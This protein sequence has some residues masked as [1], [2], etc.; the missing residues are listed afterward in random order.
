M[1]N[2]HAIQRLCTLTLLPATLSGGPVAHAAPATVPGLPA[3]C[4]VPSV[5]TPAEQAACAAAGYGGVATPPAPPSAPAPVPPPVPPAP[6]S[7]LDTLSTPL[8]AGAAQDLLHRL[9]LPG[10]LRGQASHGLIWRAG[11]GGEQTRRDATSMLSGFRVRAETL[12]VGVDRA[13]GDDWAVGAALALTRSRTHFEGNASGQWATSDNLTLYTQWTPWAGGSVSL[14]AS[15][16]QSAYQ[17]QRDGG[18][19]LLARSSPSGSGSGLAL[20]AGHDVVL[21]AWSVSPYLR[22]DQVRVRVDAFQESGAS[23]ALAVGAQAL[24]ACTL[25]AGANLQWSVPQS[26]GLLLPY[27]RMEWSERRDRPGGEVGGRLLSDNS[28]LLIPGAGDER[29]HAGSVAVGFTALTQRSFSTFVDFQTGFAQQ[30]Y[31]IQ[32]L[33]A[34]LRFEL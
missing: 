8:V 17:V 20:T 2:R 21:G 18:G 4:A 11:G 15:H 13:V 32:R 22:W 31:R 29:S 34:G 1:M 33:G 23:D 28:A 16:E 30:G 5:L 25:S 19:G 7:G 26:W 9:R 14:A 3:S 10:A 24:R 6:P 12:S 27:L